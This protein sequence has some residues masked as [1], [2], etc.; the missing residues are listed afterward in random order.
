MSQS[1]FLGISL[2]LIPVFKFLEFFINKLE[3][4]YSWLWAF[5]LMIFIVLIMKS[6]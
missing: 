1:K 4:T 2:I 6:K 3:N 5:L